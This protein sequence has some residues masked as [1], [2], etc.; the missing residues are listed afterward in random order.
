VHIAISLYNQTTRP[1]LRQSMADKKH[2]EATAS[3][4]QS[5]VALDQTEEVTQSAERSIIDGS[6]GQKGHPTEEALQGESQVVN[7]PH[8]VVTSTS[9]DP[10]AGQDETTTHGIDGR[11]EADHA[12]GD[13]QERVPTVPSHD[14]FDFLEDMTNGI[15]ALITSH[16]LNNVD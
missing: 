2:G 9:S 3:T 12:G 1:D 8:D 6:P 14:T 15:Y 5:K 16:V 11:G 10:Q 4:G 13:G 7:S